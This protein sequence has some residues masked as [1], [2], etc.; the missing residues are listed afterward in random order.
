VNPG[1]RLPFTIGKDRADYGTDV[2]YFPNE[3][4]GAPQLSFTEGVFIDYRAFDYANITPA[5]EFGYGLSY[6]SFSYSGL[7]VKKIPVEGY[8]TSV[9]LTEPAPTLGNVSNITEEYLFPH[10]IDPVARYIY[11]YLNKTEF[12][13]STDGEVY[14]LPE[15]SQDGSPQPLH[16]AGGAPGGNPQL[17]DVLYQI[18]ATITNTGNVAGSEVPQL[19][20]SLGG[21]Y[22]PKVVLRGFE[23]LSIEPGTSAQFHVDLTRRDLSNWDPVSQNWA[24]SKYM[25]T[26]YVGSSSRKFH[27][28]APLD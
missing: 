4:T 22:D 27:L 5:Y 6:T 18:S 3:G 17:Y 19:Y 24:I 11:P 14:L 16:P 21:P 28:K 25:K 13:Q 26:V 1:A 23:R 12:E 10:D 8:T 9:G 2:L 7:E 15:G 20:L